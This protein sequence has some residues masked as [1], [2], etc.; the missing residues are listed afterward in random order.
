MVKVSGELDEKSV[1]G[2]RSFL[3]LVLLGGGGAQLGPIKLFHKNKSRLSFYKAVRLLIE[4]MMLLMA[5][6]LH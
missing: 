6:Y 2:S 1:L 5:K 4:L 3:L